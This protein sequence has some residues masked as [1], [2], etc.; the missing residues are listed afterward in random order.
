VL[1]STKKYSQSIL[2]CPIWLYHEDYVHPVAIS[3][4]YLIE[5]SAIVVKDN[6]F[7]LLVILDLLILHNI[8]V[9]QI[10]QTGASAP[11]R[12]FWP[13]EKCKYCP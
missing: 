10:D 4:L 5:H 6:F 2:L 13:V 3:K 7:A 8:P 9:F 1:E 12:Y 11:T